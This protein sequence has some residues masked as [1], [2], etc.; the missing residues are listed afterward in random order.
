MEK[1]SFDLSLTEDFKHQT[2]KEAEYYRNIV[3]AQADHIE[4]LKHNVK[5]LQ[6]QLQISYRRIGELTEIV[7]IET[8]GEAT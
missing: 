8:A 1:K 5:E 4:L 6:C 2:D 3:I 7:E